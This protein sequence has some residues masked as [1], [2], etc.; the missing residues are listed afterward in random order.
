MTTARIVKFLFL[1]YPELFV[2]CIIK[3]LIMVLLSS[4]SDKNPVSLLKVVTKNSQIQIM[5]TSTFWN[6]I[7]FRQSTRFSKKG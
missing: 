6:N 4:I 3:L 2:K 7:H 1:E 5:M